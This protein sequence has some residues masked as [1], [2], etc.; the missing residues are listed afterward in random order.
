MSK[1]RYWFR[2]FGVLISVPAMIAFIVGGCV[3]YVKI[4]EAISMD[5]DWL[6]AWI[7]APIWVPMLIFFA[8][9]MAVW[10]DK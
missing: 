2:F 5:R 10:E 4:G 9:R 3:V 1:S 8:H 7:L 6:T